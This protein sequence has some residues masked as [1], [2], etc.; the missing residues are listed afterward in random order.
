MEVSE[1]V[2][3][4]I[5][6]IGKVQR[7]NLNKAKELIS[8]IEEE[9]RVR[10]MK[11]VIAVCTP[12][13]NPIAVHAMDDAYLASFDIA[14]KK[15]Y[16]SVALK[17]ST[18]ELSLLAAQGGPLYGIDKADNGRIII[19]GGGIPL[20]KNGIIIGGLGVSGGTLEQDTSLAEY[21]LEVLE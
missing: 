13:G 4:V 17:M 9:A 19:F 20:I 18:K 10:N 12:E 11:V 15:A 3:A 5:T 14:M 8:K 2:Q 16:T 21:G 7:I 6:Q 1:I